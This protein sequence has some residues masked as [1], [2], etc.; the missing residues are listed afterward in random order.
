MA[1]M[2]KVLE[3]IITKGI[4]YR[5]V[6]PEVHRLIAGMDLETAAQLGSATLVRHY[7]PHEQKRWF[8]ASDPLLL[9]WSRRNSYVKLHGFLTRDDENSAITSIKKICL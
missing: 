2:V 6:A 7:L 1:G 9:E 8:A 5:D 4:D 3:A